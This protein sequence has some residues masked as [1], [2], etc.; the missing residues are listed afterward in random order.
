MHAWI[1]KLCQATSALTSRPDLHPWASHLDQRILGLART[2]EC[3]SM[4]QQDPMLSCKLPKV[5]AL[6]GSVLKHAIQVYESTMKEFG[7]LVFKF[8]WTHCPVF[9]LRNKKFGYLNDVLGWE[10]MIILYASSEAVGPS[11][12][13]SALIEKYRGAFPLLENMVLSW[14]WLANVKK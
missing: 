13:E 9:R 2:W 12:L 8:G 7:P 4:V 5:G 1:L 3:F 11:F 6:S 14:V 10:K